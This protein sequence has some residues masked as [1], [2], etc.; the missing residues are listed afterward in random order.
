MGL[1]K[2]VLKKGVNPKAT[3]A[4][5]VYLHWRGYIWIIWR[6]DSKNLEHKRSSRETV[7]VKISDNK[8]IKLGRKRYE[9]HKPEMSQEFIV[10]VT[11]HMGLTDIFIMECCLIPQYYLKWKS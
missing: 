3:L 5:T 9:E 2:L 8:V 4:H 6:Y 11:L 1:S 10:H 7:T